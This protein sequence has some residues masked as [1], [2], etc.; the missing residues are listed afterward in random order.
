ML[1][2][3]PHHVHQLWR[4]W[5]MWFSKEELSMSRKQQGEDLNGTGIGT[6]MLQHLDDL[7][8]EHV[9]QHHQILILE[10]S[11][12]QKVHPPLASMNL[13]LGLIDGVPNI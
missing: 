9:Q 6:M 1:L 11:E 3:V 13:L 7:R 10:S 12:F 4:I 5:Q 8:T 2:S